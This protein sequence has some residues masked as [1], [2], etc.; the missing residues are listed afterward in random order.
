[1]TKSNRKRAG[2][3]RIQG[4]ERAPSGAISRSKEA[5]MTVEQMERDRIKAEHKL[6]LEA[7]TWKRRQIDPTLSVEQARMMEHGSVIAKML[8]QYRD[9]K[10]RRPDAPHPNE[11]TQLHYDTALRFG[12]LHASYMGA[13]EA[14]QQR[15]SSDFDGAK[16]YDGR[17]PFDAAAA[18]RHRNVEDQYKAARS[19]ILESGSLCMMAVE[20][21]ILE[22]KPAFGMLPDLRLAL[23]R[24]AVLWRLQQAA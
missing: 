14:K 10:K 1:M 16:G 12:E 4:I 24:L 19:A 11:F 13:I 18:R 15:S 17:D 22:N 20:A 8:A 3:K 9:A 5:Q 7:A 21:I 23:N 6:T 2:R